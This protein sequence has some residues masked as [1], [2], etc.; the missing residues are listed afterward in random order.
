MVSISQWIYSHL[1]SDADLGVTPKALDDA[2]KDL[3]RLSKQS[4][5]GVASIG[6]RWVIWRHCP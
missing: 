2:S 1:P 3:Q 4:G 5:N 6:A